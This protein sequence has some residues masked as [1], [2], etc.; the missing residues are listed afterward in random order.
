M[1]PRIDVRKTYKL[2]M[3]GEFVRS[4]SG[5]SYHVE[6]SE[7]NLPRA[8]RKDVRDA[9]QAARTAFP[10]WAGKTATNRGQIL[11]RISE[12]LDSRRSE[13][14]ALLGG[15]RRAYHEVDEAV[16]AFVWYAGWTDKITQVAGTVNPVGG[17]YFN[18]TIPEPTGVVGIVLPEIPALLSAVRHIAPAICSGNTVVALAPENAPLSAL[19]LA[20]VFSTSDVPGGT[21]NILSGY[22]QELVSWL[23]SHMDVN[24]IDISGC[25]SDDVSKVQELAALNVK[26]VVQGDSQLS[27]HSITSLM[28]FKTVW[29]PIGV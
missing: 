22:R 6:G 12:M 14:A 15:G 8:S 20:E 26:R 19:T 1:A 23:G 21:V 17:P 25:S 10:G 9:V 2:F 18:F 3:K 28:E 16:E 7:I 27:P 29:H 13:F 11:Y 5:R 4:E 24:A